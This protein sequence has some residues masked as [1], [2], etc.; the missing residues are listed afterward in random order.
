M[1]KEC[2]VWSSLLV[3]ESEPGFEFKE[4]GKGNDQSA[5]RSDSSVKTYPG[6][7]SR[8]RK[9]KKEPQS[10]LPHFNFEVFIV[11]PG[12]IHLGTTRTCLINILPAPK[13]STTH[14]I[15]EFRCRRYRIRL[16]GQTTLFTPASLDNEKGKDH[17]SAIETVLL[18][19]KK[20]EG[21]DVLLSAEN[22]YA[23]RID[24]DIPPSDKGVPSFRAYNV[25]RDYT[26]QVEVWIEC[27]GEMFYLENRGSF[28]LLPPS[29]DRV[30]KGVLQKEEGDNLGDPPPAY[31]VK[32]HPE[33]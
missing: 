12:F 31:P 19:I 18:D 33:Y 30:P 24:V 22:G 16:I 8:I 5:V 11:R 6:P 4:K 23:T 13:T 1:G 28:H 9:K 25:E 2:T 17:T 29:D 15:P 21:W 32:P 7:L 20:D 3:P 14:A 26:L 27:L 10:Q